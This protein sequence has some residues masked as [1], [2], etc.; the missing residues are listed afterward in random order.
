MFGVGSLLFSAVGKIG[1]KKTS[2][3]HGIRPSRQW[4]RED[5]Y[6]IPVD[7]RLILY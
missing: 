2:R 7:F 1:E 3:G 6:V 4:W 5:V